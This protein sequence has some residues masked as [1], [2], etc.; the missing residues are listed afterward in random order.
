M[1]RL[2]GAQRPRRRGA[3]NPTTVAPNRA[4]TRTSRSIQCA[5]RIPQV[6]PSRKL[7]PVAD[8]GHAGESR[9]PAPPCTAACP[10]SAPAYLL[11]A[12]NEFASSRA[13][14]S[15]KNRAKP[16]PSGRL[17]PTPASRSCAA[18]GLVDGGCASLTPRS[19]CSLSR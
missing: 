2:T 13:R 11:N 16:V 19:P 14:P 7:H 15:T 4:P 8:F 10:A 9:P 3:P 5:A 1:P 12:T 17:C 18:E 6:G